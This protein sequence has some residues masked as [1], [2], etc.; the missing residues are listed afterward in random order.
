MDIT[1]QA[2]PAATESLYGWL[3]QTLSLLLRCPGLPVSA[4]A[5]LEVDNGQPSDAVIS[6]LA[7]EDFL[8]RF[9]TIGMA[10]W[11]LGCLRLQGIYR[12]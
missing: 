11:L 7:A 6:L 12:S 2:E 10:A 1:I 5:V 8:W 4:H 9:T 3:W